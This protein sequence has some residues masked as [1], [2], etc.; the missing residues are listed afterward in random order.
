LVFS[1]QKRPA[2]PAP[3]GPNE[4]YA[5]AT[6]EAGDVSKRVALLPAVKE[7]ALTY[8]GTQV[9]AVR[10]EGTP[11]GTLVSV[12]VA[13]GTR[14]TEISQNV[15][16]VT[17]VF[18]ELGRDVGVVA[19]TN[20]VPDYGTA[21]VY[22]DRANPTKGLSLGRVNRVR[23]SPDRR[24]T[25]S[26]TVFDPNTGLHNLRLTD[27]MTGAE[28]FLETEAKATVNFAQAFSTDGRLVFWQLPGAQVDS[29]PGWVGT[30]AGCA[31]KRQYSADMRVTQEIASGAFVYDGVRAGGA[32]F[33]L[34]RVRF[35]PA[36]AATIQEEIISEGVDAFEVIR[37]EANVVFFESSAAGREGLYAVTLR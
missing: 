33:A 3:A 23:V 26:A 7:F 22:L 36:T 34:Y 8:D 32:G 30:T 15:E 19:W 1:V 2:A 27:N 25:L 35:D 18:D 4:L 9:V 16:G 14:V 10:D 17:V 29:R 20:R 37:P 28:C 21:T 24:Y 13:T 11:V 31:T 6:A 12:D 5:I